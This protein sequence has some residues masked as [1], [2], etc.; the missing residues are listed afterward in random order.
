MLD[1]CHGMFAICRFS[2]NCGHKLR[3]EVRIQGRL[4]FL[5]CIHDIGRMYNGEQRCQDHLGQ[6]NIPDAS[7]IKTL[8]LI[9]FRSFV[10]C[11][12][13]KS[14][15]RPKILLFAAQKSEEPLP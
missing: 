6:L 10:G 14:W 11:Y 9:A 7:R 12:A 2:R 4:H 13:K 1:I 5:Y 8:R 3:W 15:P